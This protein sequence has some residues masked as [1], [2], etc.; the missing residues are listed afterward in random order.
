[1]KEDV[2]DVCLYPEVITS[3]FFVFIPEAKKHGGII[4]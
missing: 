4:Q 1:M 2:I 3:G